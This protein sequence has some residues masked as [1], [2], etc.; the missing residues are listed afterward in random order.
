MPH[1]FYNRLMT[2]QTHRHALYTVDQVRALD[3][4]AIDDLGIPGYELMRRAAWAALSS[5]RRHWPYARRIAVYAGQG[6]NGGDGF[7][8]AAL[9]SEASLHVDVWSVGGPSHGDAA[10]A[11]VACEAAH[12]HIVDGDAPDVLAEAEIGRASVGKE[13]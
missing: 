6:N 8:L 12:V 11:R 5:L 2:P 7:L 3:R 9:A 1:R 4:R 10:R 13:C